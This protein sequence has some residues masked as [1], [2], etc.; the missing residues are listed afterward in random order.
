MRPTKG[1]QRFDEIAKVIDDRRQPKVPSQQSPTRNARRE[2]QERDEKIASQ[3]HNNLPMRGKLR[4]WGNWADFEVLAHPLWKRARFFTADFA[5]LGVA[6]VT[7]L[8]RRFGEL[9]KS[10]QC[11]DLARIFNVAWVKFA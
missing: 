7:G 10:D 4:N 5:D 2:R 11:A 3:N 6:K 1:F 8:L 9:R